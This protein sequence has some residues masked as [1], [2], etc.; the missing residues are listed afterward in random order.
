MCGRCADFDGV[1]L[2][3]A[4]LNSG[5]AARF[6]IRTRNWSN[7]QAIRRRLYATYNGLKFHAVDPKF[8]TKLSRIMEFIDKS[9]AR[10]ARCMEEFRENES[11]LLLEMLG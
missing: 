3:H 5:D 7:R 8:L 2:S 1:R 9:N 10:Y 4:H 11:K 6:I